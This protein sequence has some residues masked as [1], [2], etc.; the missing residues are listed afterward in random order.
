MATAR[1]FVLIR[2]GG[3]VIAPHHPT[4]AWYLPLMYTSE[5]LL[6]K[7]APMA[8][9]SDEVLKVS[10]G[11][12]R[13]AWESVISANFAHRRKWGMGSVPYSGRIVIA[14]ATQ[15]LELILLGNQNGEEI[16]TRLRRATFAENSK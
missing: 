10:R 5:K 12:R 4:D 1:H 16:E 7:Y 13:I 3:V 11:N 2:T 15:Q 6:S 9:D 14:T 8:A